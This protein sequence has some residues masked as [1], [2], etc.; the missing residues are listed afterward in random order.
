[1]V[2]H[3]LD[4]LAPV[5]RFRV[6]DPETPWFNPQISKMVTDKDKAYTV[7]KSC[8]DLNA[9]ETYSSVKE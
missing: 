3:L 6:E 1:M 9:Y 7:W 2:I 5:K 4:Q 8:N